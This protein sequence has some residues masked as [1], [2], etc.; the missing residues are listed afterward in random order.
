[1]S[2]YV[3][4]E[5]YI[6]RFSSLIISASL[7]LSYSLSLLLCLRLF[8]SIYIHIYSYYAIFHSGSIVGDSSRAALAGILVSSQDNAHTHTHQHTNTH[9]Q[10]C[11][12]SC[13]G[14]QSFVLASWISAKASS[15]HRPRRKTLMMAANE[16]S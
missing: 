10:C 9:T 12:D 7:C 2:I 11:S 5:R 3:C 13:H 8:L 15:C 6:A 1:M 4:N 16:R 14:I